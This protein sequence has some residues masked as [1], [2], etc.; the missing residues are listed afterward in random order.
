MSVNFKPLLDKVLIK[1]DAAEETTVSGIIIPSAAKQKPQTGTVVAVGDK[2]TTAK[3]GDKVF[4]PHGGGAEI[5]IDK[6]T[7]L[8]LRESDILGIYG[9]N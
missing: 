6:S 3:D 9:R 1:V 4:F 5:T 2:A 8:I 7:Y